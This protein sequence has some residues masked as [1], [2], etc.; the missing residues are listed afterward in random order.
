MANPRKPGPRRPAGRRPAKAA[1]RPPRAARPGTSPRPSRGPRPDSADRPRR[2]AGSKP[3]KSERPDRPARV[4]RPSSPRPPAKARAARPAK[5]ARSG[6]PEPRLDIRWTGLRPLYD[7][8]GNRLT[9]YYKLETLAKAVEGLIRGRDR[10]IVSSV[11]QVLGPAPLASLVFELF[12]EGRY[13]LIF[14]VQAT[15]T[16][17]K[18]ALFGFVA[19]KRPGDFSKLAAVEH[20]NLRILN[21]R[22]PE[23][24][25]RPFQGGRI[26]LAG[27]RSEAPREIYAYLTQWLGTYHE[28]GVAKSLQFYVNVK[29]PQI[30]T[31]S[32][33]ER[34]KGQIVEVI[35]RSY[36]PVKRTCME[37]PE[38]ASGDFVVTKPTQASPRIKLIAC[39][40]LLRNMNPAKIL[41]RILETHGDWGGRDFRLAPAEAETLVEGLERALGRD[42]ARRWLDLYRAQLEAGTFRPLPPLTGEDLARVLS[43][44]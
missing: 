21:E 42:E 11:Q 8:W 12:Q 19:A 43:K 38:I 34:I 20:E 44:G 22:D 41:H 37:M 32:Q 23:H 39:R 10:F 35:A 1:D 28:M 29:N 24:V 7:F 5:P 2:S 9:R 40:R 33:T 30:F 3:E 27:P 18:Q 15:N 36:D 16:K 17:R 13:Q 4:G 31:L 6:R 26:A 14:R 25:V